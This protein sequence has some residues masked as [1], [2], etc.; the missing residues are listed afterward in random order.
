M[1]ESAGMFLGWIVDEV[2]EALAYMGSATRAKSSHD[3]QHLHA[4]DL[5]LDFGAHHFGDHFVIGYAVGELRFPSVDSRRGQYSKDRLNLRQ[6]FG[7][8]IPRDIA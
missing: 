5:A 2:L 8:K 7:P 6:S 1:R 3:G 4:P